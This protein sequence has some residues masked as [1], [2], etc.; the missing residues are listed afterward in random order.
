MKTRW[1]QNELEEAEPSV[2]VEIVKDLEQRLKKK[3]E[4][5]TR[6]RH[7]LQKARTN[8][9]RLKQIIAYQRSRLVTLHGQVTNEPTPPPDRPTP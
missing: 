6:T 1:K 9:Q 2:L 8:V 5:L 3:T 7:R 4:D